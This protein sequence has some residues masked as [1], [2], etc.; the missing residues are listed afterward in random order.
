MQIGRTD[1]V[2]RVITPLSATSRRRDASYDPYS[3]PNTHSA[4][5]GCRVVGC[6]PPAAV[7]LGAGTPGTAKSQ[8]GRAGFARRSYPG[9]V[10]PGT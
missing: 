3:C 4:Q 1:A 8:P 6:D 2:N 9:I 5:A 10:S 7:R